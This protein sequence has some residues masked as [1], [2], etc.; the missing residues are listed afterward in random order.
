MVT[1]SK[2]ELQTK[3]YFSYETCVAI[4][5]IDFKGNEHKFRRAA[6]FSA[7]TS[8]HLNKIGATNWEGLSDT[9][10]DAYLTTLT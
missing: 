7:T 1:I 8:R 4:R 3:L 10:F 5:H 6:F 9:E 2:Y